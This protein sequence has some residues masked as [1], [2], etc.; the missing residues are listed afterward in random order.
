MTDWTIATSRTTTSAPERAI[1]GLGKFKRCVF[2]FALFSCGCA[3]T[4][5]SPKTA[6]VEHEA[7]ASRRHLDELYAMDQLDRTSAVGADDDN[8]SVA[9]EAGIET[10]EDVFSLDALAD[11]GDLIDVETLESDSE[12]TEL[13]VASDEFSQSDCVQILKDAS[14]TVDAACGEFSQ[15]D[16][17]PI[18]GDVSDEKVK[19][20][21]FVSSIE[22]ALIPAGSFEMGCVPQDMTCYSWEL[23]QHTITISAFHIG[24]NEVTAAQYQACVAGGACTPPD[25]ESFCSPQKYGTY[26]T[27]GKEKHPINCVTW[28]QADAFC[29]WLQPAGRLPTEAEW[30]RVARG[31]LNGKLFV[32]GDLAPTCAPGQPNTIVWSEQAVYGCGEDSTWPVGEGSAQN[33]FGLHDMSGNVGEWT[34][35]WYD[36][37]YY[38]VS[39]PN[40]PT[41][42]ATGSIRTIRGASFST[43]LVINLRASRREGFA[44][45]QDAYN[46]GFRCVQP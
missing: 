46:L 22:T 14:Q 43:H 18:P 20:D 21:A 33:G 17:G 31:G 35:D 7:D 8:A 42:P 24:V 27:I 13:D 10:G 5:S 29:K 26:G 1:T 12:L 32:W 11:E 30:E 28:F 40:D 9:I 36:D 44:A 15:Q 3:N 37:D 41:G 6:H 16:G 39:L 2:I 38:Q 23:P 19:V 4:I 45:E 25:T 34:S